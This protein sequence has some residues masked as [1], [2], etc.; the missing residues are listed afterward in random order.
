M[1]P[2]Y[3]VVCTAICTSIVHSFPQ[4][5]SERASE[6]AE[7]QF[8]LKQMTERKKRK[9][10]QK[11]SMPHTSCTVGMCVAARVCGSRSE[12]GLHRLLTQPTVFCQHVPGERTIV[13]LCP[14]TS[15]QGLNL[16]C[17]NV[18][19]YLILVSISQ[20]QFGLLGK[21]GYCSA[22][23]YGNGMLNTSQCKKVPYLEKYI[24]SVHIMMYTLEKYNYIGK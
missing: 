17:P 4:S 19:A 22:W 8:L 24:Y 14:S 1:G 15:T 5:D 12:T 21:Q 7:F 6:G 11:I 16:Q 18:L 13:K 10:L 9:C 2:Q 20:Y 3:N 23:Q